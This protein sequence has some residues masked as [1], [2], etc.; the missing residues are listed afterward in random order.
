[1]T[2]RTVI[3][4]FPACGHRTAQL[5]DVIDGH[6]VCKIGAW[7]FKYVGASRELLPGDVLPSPPPPIDPGTFQ[8]RIID[9]VKPRDENDSFNF[10]LDRELGIK[11]KPTHA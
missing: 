3:F 6:H 1:M 10:K 11:P 7:T 2:D 8:S 9:K 5:V 4:P